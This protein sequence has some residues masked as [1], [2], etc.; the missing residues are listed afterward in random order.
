MM[1]SCSNNQTSLIII[2]TGLVKMTN[3]KLSNPLKLIKSILTH[4]KRQRKYI[5][6]FESAVVTLR[7][8]ELSTFKFYQSGL[9]H[10]NSVNL[11]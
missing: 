6:S 10:K 3:R 5:A 8:K 4:Q 2:T 9:L 1:L 7:T 11:S